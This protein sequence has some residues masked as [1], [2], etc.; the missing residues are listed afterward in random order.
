M[1]CANPAVRSAKLANGR[2][3]LPSAGFSD[4][5]RRKVTPRNG[6]PFCPVVA[7]KQRKNRQ[8]KGPF[9]SCNQPGGRCR[10]RE[11]YSNG[12]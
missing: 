6:P 9:V 8:D 3:D 11:E 10:L 12:T 1:R 4:A 7:D 2:E 5:G